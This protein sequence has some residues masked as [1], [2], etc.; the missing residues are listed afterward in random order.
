[1]IVGKVKGGDTFRIGE[2]RYCAMVKLSDAWGCRIRIGE[3]WE[4]AENGGY[5]WFTF[6]TEIEGYEA[7]FARP[8]SGGTSVDPMV[9]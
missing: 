2:D 8:S 3:S 4:H 1:M 5:Y 9:G 7:F 6:D